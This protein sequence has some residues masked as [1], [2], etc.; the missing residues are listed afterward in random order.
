MHPVK[1]FLRLSCI[2]SLLVLVLPAVAQDQTH[3]N[4][5]KAVVEHLRIKALASFMFFGHPEEYA[6]IVTP[7]AVEYRSDFG[8]FGGRLSVPSDI[9]LLLH[10]HP[11]DTSPE[12]SAKDIATAIKLGVPNCVVTLAQ[13][14]CA[15]P[16][17]KVV[18]Q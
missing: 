14:I 9:M 12:P 7:S 17:G 5:P 4:I 2:L 15:M 3:L 10:T 11:K 13:I 6:A 16:D 1:S 18:R 8:A